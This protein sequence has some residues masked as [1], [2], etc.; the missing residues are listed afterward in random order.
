MPDA[1]TAQAR[2]APADRETELAA[3]PGIGPAVAARIRERFSTMDAF[4]AAA[5]DGDVDRIAAVPGIGQRRAARLVHEIRGEPTSHLLGTAAVERVLD[6]I[7]NALVARAVTQN[8]KNRLRLIGPLTD[9]KT[10]DR[11]IQD[12]LDAAAR[13]KD[14]DLKEVRKQLADIKAL[15]APRARYE[16]TIALFVDAPGDRL[17]LQEAGIDAWAPIVSAH[18]PEAARGAECG[19]YLY[20]D[21][22]SSLLEAEHVVS[23]PFTTDLATAIPWSVTTRFESARKTLQAAATLSGIRG[24]PSPSQEALSLLDKTRAERDGYD[25]RQLEPLADTLLK[26]ALIKADAT[27]GGLTLTGRDLVR[28]L[29]SDPP[30]AVRAAYTDALAEARDKFHREAG[31][32]A[33]PF[34]DTIPPELDEGALKNARHRL[35]ATRA[36]TRLEAQ[37]K[38]AKALTKLLPAIEKEIDEHL[39]FDHEQA[40]GSYVAD[41]RLNAPEWGPGLH[42]EGALHLEH[43]DGEPVDYRLGCKSDRTVDDDRVAILTGANS[44]GK[45]TLLETIAQVLV[46][47]HCGLPV[48]ARHA[49]IPELDTIHLFARQRQ[50]G[51]GAFEAFLTDLFPVTTAT[52]RVFVLADEL[53]AM[54]ELEAAAAIVADLLDGLH[55]TGAHALVVTHMAKHILPLV[56]VPVRI[57]GIE[58]EGL[59][60]DDRLI[61]RRSP[62]IGHHARSTPELILTRLARHGPED[63]RERF[64]RLAEQVK[65]DAERNDRSRS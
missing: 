30:P 22:G 2:A 15:P 3:L 17:A 18:D 45:T 56:S 4:L 64:A 43:Q 57:D 46:M 36:T 61:V 59:D 23:V 40:L 19:L 60:E 6:D 10:R 7:R 63:L 50:L 20:S 14:L 11:S 5:S 58:A 31:L 34:T 29:S 53:E 35:E 49:V 1:A 65:S 26:E 33:D 25:P 51:A 37:T 16:A 13:V 39:A 42:L 12:A 8:G 54:T 41:H 9:R 38:T 47:A 62:R 55:A 48:P 52:G 24:K 28:A 21:G 44:G 27:L 32:D